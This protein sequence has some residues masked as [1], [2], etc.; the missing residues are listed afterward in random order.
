MINISD[1]QFGQKRRLVISGIN[2]WDH[3]N[4][5]SLNV[6]FYIQILDVFG[7]VIDDKSINQ[8]R[9]VIYSVTNNNW[10]DAQFN[11]SQEGATGSFREYDYFF[12]LCGSMDIITLIT[13][14]ANK[15]NQRGI[16]E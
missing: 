10:V 11:P 7:N 14:L 16:F 8:N 15:L 13:Q 12:S 2:S 3:V 9:R 4:T 6:V 5:K 1:T